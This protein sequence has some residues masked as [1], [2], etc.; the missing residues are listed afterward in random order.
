MLAYAALAGVPVPYEGLLRAARV[1]G[2]EALTVLAELRTTQLVRI[3]RRNR[4]RLVEPYHDR[5]REAVIHE[6]PALT[7]ANPELRAEETMHLRLGRALLEVTR[8]EREPDVHLFSI[9]KHLSRASASLDRAGR[10]ELAEL[11]LR[12]GRTARNATAFDAALGFLRQGLSLLPDDAW[13]SAYELARMLSVAAVEAEYLVGAAPAAE[14]RLRDLLP[15]MATDEERADLYVL[16]AE[17]D[18]AQQRF[19]D[20]IAAVHDGLALFGVRLPRKATAFRILLEYGALA[21]RWH[22]RAPEAILALPAAASKATRAAIKLLVALAPPAFSVAT[23]LFAVG[24][25]RIARISLREGVCEGSAYGFSCYGLVLSAALG[26]AA[27]ADRLGRTAFLLNES[28]GS[29]ALESRSC[30][31]TA[32]PSPHGRAPS[33]KDAP[34]S[35][36]VAKARSSTVTSATRLTTRRASSPSRWARGARSGRPSRR[37]KSRSPSAVGAATADMIGLTEAQLRFCRAL[38]GTGERK[39]RGSRRPRKATRR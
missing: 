10:R 38:A 36:A 20:A 8:A 7:T 34:S 24:M 29:P 16:K 4:T 33:A 12:A 14:A 21:L 27:F 26:K 35:Y 30:S 9:V 22:G 31:S 15:R 13:T 37:S 19:E 5:V 39:F 32:R 23:N 17:M 3:S 25:M 6:L 18:T 28:S 1:Q 11:C 2:A